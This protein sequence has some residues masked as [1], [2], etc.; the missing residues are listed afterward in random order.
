MTYKIRKEPLEMS[1]KKFKNASD[2]DLIEQSNL[3]VL[4]EN[5]QNVTDLI[6]FDRQLIDLH[7]FNRAQRLPIYLKTDREGH[8]EEIGYLSVTLVKKH[9]FRY[10][11]IALLLIVVVGGLSTCHQHS[12]NQ[13]NATENSQQDQSIANNHRKISQAM[14]QIDQLDN[15]VK[16]LK[17]AIKQYQQDNNKAAFEQ[18][19]TTIQQQVEQLQQNQQ[20]Q[21]DHV[22]ELINKINDLI[23]QLKQVN[24]PNEAGQLMN[25]F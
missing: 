20:V 23:N 5:D 12:V 9:I 14:Q 6:R 17:D 25:R 22:V 4:N 21:S 2:L 18:Q 24:N 1:V 15:E 19:L 11:L 7:E 8:H 3:E 10:I 13:Q 16:Q